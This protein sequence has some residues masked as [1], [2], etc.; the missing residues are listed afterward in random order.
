M[1]QVNTN[2]N[3]KN[4]N[5]IKQMCGNLFVYGT[6]QHGQSR[7]YL[8]TGLSFEKAVLY[9]YRKIFPPHLG[10]PLI[11][12][13]KNSEVNGEVYFGVK[14][15]LFNMLDVIEGVGSLYHRI[16]VNLETITK[17]NHDA[18][19]YYPSKKLIDSCIKE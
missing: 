6:L 4:N 11:T 2:F 13:D 17:K 16:L 10:F 12:R 9:G 1:P 8:L 14:R 5:N 3:N 18:F 15:S 7:N 19:V